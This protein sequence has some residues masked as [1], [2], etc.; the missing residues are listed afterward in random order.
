MGRIPLVW[1]AQRSYSPCAPWPGLFKTTRELPDYIVELPGSWENL[2]QQLSVNMRKNLRKAYQG[3]ARDGFAFALR[4][5]ERPEAVADAMARFFTLHGA[6]SEA[7]DMIFHANRFVHPNVRA[8][9]MEYL[10]SVAERGEL[11]IFELEIGGVV[12]ASRIALLLGSDLYMHLAGY[13]PA[14]KTYSVM[15]VLVAETFK[16]ALAHGVERINLSSSQD[17]SKM[18]WKPHEV[19]FRDVVQVSPALRARAAFG[20]FRAYEALGGARLKATVLRTRE[21]IALLDRI[22]QNQQL[23]ADAG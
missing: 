15:T 2:H 8:F 10:H 3:L 6:R 7:A 17:Q 9:F 18:R 13:N 20:V 1:P 14:W 21:G 4:V 23:D 5:T 19:L 11:R 22:W 12:V 16:W